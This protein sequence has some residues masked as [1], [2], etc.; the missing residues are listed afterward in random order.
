MT[1]MT[2]MTSQSVDSAQSAERQKCV[3]SVYRKQ[4]GKGVRVNNVDVEGE[5]GKDGAKVKASTTV[6]GQGW[7]SGNS[8]AK[9]TERCD[10]RGYSSNYFI[11]NNFAR[12]EIV[13][14]GAL[15]VSDR[16]EW[17]QST[18]DDVS[19]VKMNLAPISE[20]FEPSYVNDILLDPDDPSQGN[21]DGDLL[22][23]SFTN[24]VQEYCQLVLGEDCPP[25][26]GCATYGLCT[27]G[28]VCRDDPRAPNG[29]RCVNAPNPC[30]SQST[31]KKCRDNERCVPDNER[32]DGYDCKRGCRI[33]NDCRR[34]ETCKD[35]PNKPHGYECHGSWSSWSEK[36]L[37]KTNN[38]PRSWA[39]DR[40]RRY[41]SCSRKPCPGSWVEESSAIPF[42]FVTVPLSNSDKT[43]VYDCQ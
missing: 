1:T 17:L 4:T 32:I 13:S 42:I 16:D 35:N 31:G 23:D 15:P 14:V 28:K 29:F 18:K 27:D 39:A 30:D 22:K 3:S 6:G 19:V 8:Y 43:P 11:Q 34:D 21:L 12:T 10:S 5:L 20:L 36:G 38:K 33:Y 24:I 2:W 40:C 7:G 26:T 41:R 25:V 9:D 37:V